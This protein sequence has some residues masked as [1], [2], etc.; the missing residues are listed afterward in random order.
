MNADL[1]VLK[2]VADEEKEKYTA[3]LKGISAEAV[4]IEVKLTGKTDEILGIFQR[5]TSWGFSLGDPK[6]KKL[7]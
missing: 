2:T 1:K 5:L 4:E 6:Q 7:G 3:V